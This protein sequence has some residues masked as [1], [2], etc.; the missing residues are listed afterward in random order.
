M[1]VNKSNIDFFYALNQFIKNIESQDSKLL[2]RLYLNKEALIHKNVTTTVYLKILQYEEVD[3]FLKA[4]LKLSKSKRKKF[5]SS[6]VWKTKALKGNDLRVKVED[7]K[8]VNL[9]SYKRLSACKKHL[10]NLF[11]IMTHTRWAFRC[12][13]KNDYNFCRYIVNNA[14]KNLLSWEILEDAISWGIKI[15]SK[16]IFRSNSY[17]LINSYF[18]SLTL[19]QRKKEINNYKGKSKKIKNRLLL[20]NHSCPEELF[21]EICLEA[22]TSIYSMK[23]MWAYFRAGYFRHISQ[24]AIVETIFDLSDNFITSKVSFYDCEARNVIRHLVTTLRKEYRPLCLRVLRNM[25]EANCDESKSIVAF[26]SSDTSI[27]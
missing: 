22:V 18:K 15:N 13:A 19:E 21:K 2:E 26:M 27:L 8:E 11:V 23:A 3:V 25:G 16:N 6:N 9:S 12:I 14:T 5:V 1:K 10:D 7:I 20:L 24:E 17:E 4:F